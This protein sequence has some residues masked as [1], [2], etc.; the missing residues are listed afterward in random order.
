MIVYDLA[1]LKL[2]DIPVLIHDSNILKRVDDR[3]LERL[4]ECY[5]K[6]GHQVFVAYDRLSGT[7]DAAHDKLLECAA[8]KL[9][10]NDLLFGRPWSK[11]ENGGNA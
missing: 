3:Q 4:L 7:T 8:L 1:I 5:E 11:K 10:E 2:C 9:S 6:S